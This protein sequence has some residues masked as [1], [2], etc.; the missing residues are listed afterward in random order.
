MET[1]GREAR[2]LEHDRPLVREA[3]PA[4]F[5]DRLALRDSRPRA[6]SGEAGSCSALQQH[7]AR[8]Q[9]EP[10]RLLG[11]AA[12]VGQITLDRRLADERTSPATDRAADEPAALE[13]RQRLTEGETVDAEPR[14][15]F[16]LGRQAV[17]RLQRRRERIA[18]SITSPI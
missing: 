13:V 18:C 8:G 16:A 9:S 15:E 4:D 7:G 6:T 5:E 17:A 3:Q 11:E 2:R 10:A 14:G 12:E 1:V